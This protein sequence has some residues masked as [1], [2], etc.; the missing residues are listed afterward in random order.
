[1]RSTPLRSSSVWTVT[2]ATVAAV[3]L[4]GATARA[5]SATVEDTYAAPGPWAVR[6]STV[7]TRFVVH[8]PADLGAG[9]VRHPVVT[10]GNGSNAT[11]D[12][13]PGLLNH[14][15]SWGFVVIAST[16]TTTAS[17][18]ELLA[19]VDHLVA[20][21]DDP[22]SPFAGTLDVSR[23][24]AAGHSQGA[25][26]AARAT[27]A[28][29]RIRTVVPINP[30]D[31]LWIPDADEVDVSLVRVP[32]LLLSGT[33]DRL[34]SPPRTLTGYYNRIPGAVARASLNGADH[35]TIQQTGG[36]YLGYLAAWLRWHLMDDT[37]AATAFRGPAPEFLGDPDWTNRAA[38]NLGP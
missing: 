25:G 28:S 14:L 17:G 4:T 33:N 19:A 35:N 21:N 13:Y 37:L 26:G 38:R 8:H 30:P 1:M 12:R 3:T 22:A 23:V 20:A 16:S 34:V 29:S 9:G 24:A 5:G 7:D 18:V 10:W 2:V 15:A 6:V 27:L 36:G 32:V 11:P 31:P